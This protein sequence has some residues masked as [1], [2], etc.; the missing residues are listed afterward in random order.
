VSRPAPLTPAQQE[1]VA[2]LGRNWCVTSGAGCGKT[3]VLVER[4]IRFL[5][6]D[7]ELPLERLAAITFTEMAAAEMRD[8]IRRACRD[9][10]EEARSAGDAVRI[11]RWLQRYWDVDVAPI[12]TIHGFCAAIL[13]RFPI[14]AGVDPNFEMLDEAA[15]DLLLRDVVCRTVEELLEAEDADVLAMLEHYD[16]KRGREVLAEIVGP[17]REVLRRVAEPVMAR[18]DAEILKDLK[19][20]SDA[21]VR[22]ACEEVLAD[23]G[24]VRAL[25]DLRKFSGKAGDKREAIRL[26]MLE[27]VDRIAGARTADVATAALEALLAI[28]LRGG[29]AKHWPSAEAL[30]TV[31]D[32]TKILKDAFKEVNDDLPVFDEA[33][34]R[35][36]LAVARAMFRT[37]RRVQN[38]Y[39]EATSRSAPATSCGPT[40]ASSE[41]AEA[42]TAPSSSTN[43]RTRTSCNSKSWTCW[44]PRPGSLPAGAGAARRRRSARGRSSASATQSNP[45]TV[46]AARRSKCSSVRSGA[47]AGRARKGSP[48]V[49]G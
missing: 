19:Q 29:S 7:L 31:T 17:H 13:R 33:V 4:Y 10:L 46:S 34:E 30:Q 24:V 5:E 22:E 48:R 9:R 37:A 25:A 44:R 23:A 20:R 42:P 45:S 8:R 1:A 41:P 15:A 28:H 11:E 2:D 18:S 32:A 16:L 6:A 38:N 49:S 3:R 39:D 35:Q 36:H 12:H 43:S 21:L 47:S 14:E 26:Q 40:P 27:A